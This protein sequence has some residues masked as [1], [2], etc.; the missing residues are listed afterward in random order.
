LKKQLL[1]KSL[2]LYY[3]HFFKKPE[4]IFSRL[5]LKTAKAY[6]FF[7][8]LMAAETMP[9]GQIIKYPLL[10]GNWGCLQKTG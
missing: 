2:Y 10:Q 3:R 6:F 4:V 8:L 1:L 9:K 7:S 5:C